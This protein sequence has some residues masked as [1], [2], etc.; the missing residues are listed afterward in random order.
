MEPRLKLGHQA[1]LSVNI[2]HNYIRNSCSGCHSLQLWTS[3]HPAI[4]AP[5]HRGTED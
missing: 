4:I 5:T 1:W 2:Q 3:S